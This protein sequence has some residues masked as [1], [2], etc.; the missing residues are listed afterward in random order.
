MTESK[1]I[2]FE[3]IDGSGTSTQSKALVQNLVER[4]MPTIHT[5]EPTD[6]PIGRLLRQMLSGELTSS[7][8]PEQDRHLLALL[9]AADRHDHLWNNKDGI[10]KEL[11]QGKHV[12]CARYVL[13]SLAYE[14]EESS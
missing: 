8:S 3:G 12:V 2:V 4:G 7:D 5:W 6:R 1:F 9:F 10:K 13:S 14:G 11:A